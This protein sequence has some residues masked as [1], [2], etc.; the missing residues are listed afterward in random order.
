MIVKDFRELRQDELRTGM[1]VWLQGK[2]FLDT[3]GVAT[4]SG[5]RYHDV[6]GPYLIERVLFNNQLEPR[7]D[8]INPGTGD[9]RSMLSSWLLVPKEEQNE[10]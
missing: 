1:A 4:P 5:I 3:G 2:S 6:C 8:I 7:I 9:R 10:S